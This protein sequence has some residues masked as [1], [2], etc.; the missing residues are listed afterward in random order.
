MSNTFDEIILNNMWVTS[1]IIISEMNNNG[2]KI[3]KKDASGEPVSQIATD[4]SEV[5]E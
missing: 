3:V 5:E 1:Q 2:V 4:D